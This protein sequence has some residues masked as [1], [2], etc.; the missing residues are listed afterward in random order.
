MKIYSYVNL[1][2]LWCWLL[3]FAQCNGFIHG[4]EHSKELPYDFSSRHEVPVGIN[5]LNRISVH[6]ARIENVFFDDDSLEIVKGDQYQIFIMPK[7]REEGETIDLSI[8]FKHRLGQDLRLV[9]TNGGSRSALIKIPSN[10][11]N[12]SKQASE[13]TLTREDIKSLIA[14]L[15][16]HEKEALSLEGCEVTPLPISTL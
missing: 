2:I 16:R 8:L 4:A 14:R 6:G 3:C 12:L 7:D 1:F 15:K 11:Y 5:S 10:D 9:L 13:A